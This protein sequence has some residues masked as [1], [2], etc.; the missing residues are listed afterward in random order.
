MQFEG[1]AYPPKS[2]E[3][4]KA[5]LSVEQANTLSLSVVGNIFSCELNSAEIT[6]PMGNLPVRFTLPN[7]WVFVTDRSDEISRWFKYHNKTSLIDKA[8]S[9]GFAWFVSVL[10]CI[11]VVVGGYFYALPW[12]SDKV[13]NMIPNSVSVA[14]G[15]Q[16]LES[17]D[18]GWQPSE[19]SQTQQDEI[20]ERVNG[21]LL[22]LEKIPYPVEIVFRSSENGANAFALP[23]G[24]VVL[25]DQLVILAQ[26]QQQ[27]DSIIFHE[28][29]HIHHRHMMKKLVHSSLLSVG[30]SLL[31]GESSGIV[32]NLAGLTV[33]ILSSGY[34]RQAEAEAD[35]Y[36]SS[37]MLEI[38]GDTQA[39]VEM[40]E[41]FRQQGDTEL[42][43]WLSTHDS[44]DKRIEAI[45]SRD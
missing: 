4:H 44:L 10:V 3:R 41:L 14:I 42:P 2:S 36:A 26:T 28:L 9:N 8:E 7:G 29:G 19:L 35:A 33:F 25:L 18:H 20:R 17:L 38:Y 39:M 31:T 15:D 32:D 23:G 21:H 11:L 12:A 24:K 30:V 1:V 22:N 34:S 16:V 37:A 45:R 13:A 27:L 5:V 40:F 43:E 6:A